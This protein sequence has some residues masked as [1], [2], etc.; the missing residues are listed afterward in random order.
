[1][2][3]LGLQ[4]QIEKTEEHLFEYVTSLFAKNANGLKNE[5]KKDISLL[6][7][8]KLKIDV[9]EREKIE[10]KKNKKNQIY[11]IFID[12]H[13]EKMKEENRMKLIKKNLTNIISDTM[14]RHNEIDHLVHF[15]EGKIELI[16]IKVINCKG[17]M[18]KQVKV[19][20]YFIK[21]LVLMNCNHK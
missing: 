17:K 3:T 2:D 15:L 20:D 18:L 12:K 14:M 8:D 11:Q 21:K 4:T 13:L 16:L 6:Q 1:V 5:I 10:N 19:L 9:D 7:D